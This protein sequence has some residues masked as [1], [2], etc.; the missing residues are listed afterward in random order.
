MKIMMLIWT[1]RIEDRTMGVLHLNTPTPG[2]SYEYV[3]L[4]STALAEQGIESH[5]LCKNAPTAQ[6][7]RVLLDR[8]IRRSHV[9]VFH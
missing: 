9:F 3:A 7:G 8:V 4:L 1:Q 6:P 2:A 5:V